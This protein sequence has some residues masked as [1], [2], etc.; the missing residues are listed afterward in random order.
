[1]PVG[2][3]DLLRMS[4]GRLD[5]QTLCHPSRQFLLQ[6]FP[7]VK[8]HPDFRIKKNFT[9]SL[10]TGTLPAMLG[11]SLGMAGADGILGNEVLH[12]LKRLAYMPGRSR[13]VLE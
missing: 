11:L 1:M 6:L 13:I 4:H 3:K 10:V 12:G 5:I 9:D 2:R 7:F 8:G